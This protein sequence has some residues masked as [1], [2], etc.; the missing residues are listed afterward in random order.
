MFANVPVVALLVLFLAAAGVVW[1]AGIRLSETT[2]VLAE[3]LG[4][5]EALG[6]LVLLAI[7]TNLPEIAI[8]VSA[9]LSGNADV[10]LGN[11]LGGIAIQTVV[12]SLID[13]TVARRGQPLTTRAGS[14]VLALE[15]VTVMVMLA[16]VLMGSQLPAS[17][18]VG[19]VSAVGIAL[20]FAWIAGLWVVRS[21]RGGLPWQLKT[22][23]SDERGGDEGDGAAGRNDAG[24]GRSGVV[25]AA[26]VFGVAALATLIAGVVL[27]RAGDV[28]A[29][30]IGMEGVVFGATILAAATSLPELS[31]GIAA[32]R[33][34]EDQ[35]AISDI[36]GGNSFLPVLFLPLAILSGGAVLPGAGAANLYLTSLGIVLTA[37]FVVGVVVHSRR[38]VLRMGV[39]SLVALLV[40]ALGVVGL[41]A[42]QL[43]G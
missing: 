30:D 13:V 1:F 5:G 12:L 2:E 37:V 11:I 14:L 25:R 3:R 4:L 39:D 9:G 31:T 38:R 22:S 40:Y 15:G 32:A 16:L 8:V 42:I 34:G 33:D 26:I 41:V 20:L 7:A 6:G 21:A 10:A 35:L 27:E 23:G 29:G 17:L 36:F 43:L 18:Q 19:G 28:I 24:A